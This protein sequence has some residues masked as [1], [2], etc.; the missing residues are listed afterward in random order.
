ML[1]FQKPLR[2][3]TAYGWFVNDNEF[4]MTFVDSPTESSFNTRGDYEYLDRT[5]YTSPYLP[6]A[7][8]TT[9]LN[10]AQKKDFEYGVEHLATLN[11]LSVS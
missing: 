2:K 7:M 4:R 6:I 5:R 3:G 8:I 9:L 1:L 11:V 10:T